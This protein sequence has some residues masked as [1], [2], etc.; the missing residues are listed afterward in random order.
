VRNWWGLLETAEK[1]AASN[2][3]SNRL[4]RLKIAGMSSAAKVLYFVS[5]LAWTVALIAV[6]LLAFYFVAR[7]FLYA[8]SFVPMIGRKHRHQNWDELNRR[9]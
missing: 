9:T 5:A 2:G 8:I 4:N 3:A 7:L 1:K 6:Q